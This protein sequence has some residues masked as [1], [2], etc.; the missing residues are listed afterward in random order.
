M[1]NTLVK[2]KS[3]GKDYPN[4]GLASA[5]E[6]RHGL[7]AKLSEVFEDVIPEDYEPELLGGNIILEAARL[8]AEV[9][10][11]SNGSTI[12]LRVLGR[13]KDGDLEVE[14]IELIR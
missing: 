7:P 9:R 3:C 8:P 10:F 2:C 6:K 14:N 12:G 1:G 5:C 13:L 11:L 4:Q